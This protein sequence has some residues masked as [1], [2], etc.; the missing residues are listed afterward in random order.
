MKCEYCGYEFNAK[1][2][3]NCGAASPEMQI[4]NAPAQW[5]PPVD[6]NNIYQGDG[7]DYY[8]Y[9]NQP[10]YKRY[11]S[12]IKPRSIAACIILTILTCGLYSIIWFSNLN[13]E[14]NY[15]SDEQNPTSGGVAFILVLITCGIYY[16]YWSYKQG[17][18]IDRARALRDLP[19][20]KNGALYLILL[21]VPYVGGAISLSLM[22]NEINNLA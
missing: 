13:D 21:F 17:E 19:P 8:R 1:F 3:P 18:R 7:N 15:L 20:K 9:R 14:A 11:T 12:G 22:Q 10:I 5:Q 4:N 6:N 16:F 2:C